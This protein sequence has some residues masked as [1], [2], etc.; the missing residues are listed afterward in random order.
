MSTKEVLP[1]TPASPA[2]AR[3]LVRAQM[4][5]FSE[6]AVT[7]VELMTSELVTN[8][9]VHGSTSIEVEL[10][11]E[12][13]IW[14]VAVTDGCRE[15]PMPKNPHERDPHGRGL[16]IVQ[17]LAQ[18]WGVVENRA[19][20][21]VWFTLACQQTGPQLLPESEARSQTIADLAPFGQ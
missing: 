3:A 11:Q 12:A 1:P 18:E 17:S 4:A 10:R 19:G 13:V 7:A 15:R 6:E 5:G 14:R 9:V 21:S 8:A 2:R 20:K 16:L